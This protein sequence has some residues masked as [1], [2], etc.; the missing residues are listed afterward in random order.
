MGSGLS[1]AESKAERLRAIEVYVYRSPGGRTVREIS[2]YLG[3]N[4]RTVYRD[5]NSLSC[6]NVPICKENGKYKIDRE[7]Y[8]ATVH[9]NLN[10]AMALF[11]GARLMSKH[12]DEHNPHVVSALEKLAAACPDVTIQGHIGKAAEVVRGRRPNP[13]YVRILEA[14]TRAWADRKSLKISY[15]ALDNEV[16]ERVIDPYFLDASPVGYACYVMAYDHLRKNLRT[17]K[18]ERIEK[19]EILEQHYTIPEDFDPYA[20]LETSWGI[21]WGDE[22]EVRLR[23]SPQV[24]RRVKESQWHPTQIIE[25]CEDGSC[26]LTVRVGSTL[27]MFPWIRGWG[28]EVEVLAP[29]ELRERM[30]EE[31][32]RLRG[33]YGG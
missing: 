26:I 25:D 1:R 2:E 20:R 28:A 12:S 19:A 17:F 27:E 33:V 32:E 5:I 9:L 8:L 23:F 7:R 18:L 16:T 24:A 30:R 15:R 29:P 21:M 10:E 4:S 13:Q 6:M 22:Q 14:V 11:I 31:V 3:V